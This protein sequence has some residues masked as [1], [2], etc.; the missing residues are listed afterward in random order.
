MMVATRTLAEPVEAD[1]SL[2]RSFERFLRPSGKASLSI[3]TNLAAIDSLGRFL[4][5]RPRGLCDDR[6]DLCRLV[7][8]GWLPSP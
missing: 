1:R 5:N 7:R 4:A 8:P 2:A 6:H 3:Q